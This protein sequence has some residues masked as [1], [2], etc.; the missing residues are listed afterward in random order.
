ME[1]FIGHVVEIKTRWLGVGRKKT[2]SMLAH[3]GMLKA[4]ECELGQWW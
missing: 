2:E 3:G 1:K 4:S